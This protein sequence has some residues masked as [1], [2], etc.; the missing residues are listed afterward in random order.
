MEN[1]RR[2][3][4]SHLKKSKIF[5]ENNHMVVDFLQKK[6]SLKYKSSLSI[7]QM[8]NNFVKTDQIHIRKWTKS[9]RLW[10]LI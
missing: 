2:K 10:P 6:K 7:A 3:D 1:R 9:I 8:E 4:S 5:R